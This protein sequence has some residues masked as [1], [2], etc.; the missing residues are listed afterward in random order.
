MKSAVLRGATALIGVALLSACA[1]TREHRGQVIDKELASGIQV[2]VDNKESVEKT[3][4]R[5]T[6]TGQ[7]NQNEWYYV[8]RD[9]ATLAFRLPRVTDQTVLHVTFD[10]AGNVAS[11]NQTGEELIASIRPSGDKTPTLGRK[12]SFFEELFGNIGTITQ[13]GLGGSNRPPQQ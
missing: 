10:Q 9:T 13:P 7:F 11:V 2:G 3:L 12:Q 1:G 4:G 6:F 8:A 5:P